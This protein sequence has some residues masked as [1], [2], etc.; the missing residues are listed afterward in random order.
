MTVDPI[1]HFRG[2]AYLRINARRLE[3]LATL[4]LPIAGRSV[5]ELGAGIGDLTSYFLDRGCRVTAVDGRAE[6][7]EVMRRRFEGE[8]VEVVEADLN[9][10]PTLSASYDVVFAYGVLYHLADPAAALAWMTKL[11]GEMLV[12]ST[13]VTPNSSDGVNATTEDP[14][15]ASQALDGRAC[16]PD[17]RWVFERLGSLMPH[18]YTTLTQPAHEEFPL[19]WSAPIHSATG[20]S[21]AVFIGSRVSLDDRPLLTTELPLRHADRA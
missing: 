19:D 10:P 8:D 20:L 14:I 6:N 18:A 3:H 5:L 21:R 17:R 11:A 7:V 4:G 15:W 2:D 9:D 16:R 1:P 12:L 13:C